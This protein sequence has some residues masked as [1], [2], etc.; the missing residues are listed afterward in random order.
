MLGPFDEFKEWINKFWGTK[1]EIS[2]R[3]LA[4]A[5]AGFLSSFF[6]LPFD[7]AKTWI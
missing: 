3:L 4:S 5:M 1:D 7:N 2:T 6:S